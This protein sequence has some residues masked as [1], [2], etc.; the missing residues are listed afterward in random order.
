[1]NSIQINNLSAAGGLN[2]LKIS[3]EILSFFNPFFKAN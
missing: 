2:P 3:P 1:M